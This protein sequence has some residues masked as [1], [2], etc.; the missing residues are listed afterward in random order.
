MREYFRIANQ[1]AEHISSQFK[2]PI[3]IVLEKI[4]R[5]L[6]LYEKKKYAYKEWLSPEG[7]TEGIKYKGLSIIRRDYCSLVQEICNQI[8]E[9]L[10]SMKENAIEEAIKFTIESIQGLLD[11]KVPIEKLILSTALKGTYKI[12]GKHVVWYSGLCTL[13][14]TIKERGHA[15]RDPCSKC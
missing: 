5:P 4:M 7:P 13:H 2:E 1:C 3:K 15:K 12:K 11:G 6:F 14:D 8:F 9:I 10:M